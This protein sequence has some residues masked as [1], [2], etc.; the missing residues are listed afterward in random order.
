MKVSTETIYKCDICGNKSEWQ[1]GKWIAH[2][3][4]FGPTMLA[5]EHE[6]HVCSDECDRKLSA[7]KKDE[8]K[9]LALKI[10]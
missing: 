8:R 5:W 2:V 3:Y 1:K 10:I 9:T 4:G 6:F 7:M